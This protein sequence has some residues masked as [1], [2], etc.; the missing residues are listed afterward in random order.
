M[1]FSEKDNPTF[2]PDAPK[3]KNFHLFDFNFKYNIVQSEDAVKLYSRQAILAFSILFSVLAGG[4]LTAINAKKMGSK[5]GAWISVLYSILYIFVF[6]LIL[7][8]FKTNTGIT[9]FVNGIGGLGLSNIIW[10]KYI[11]K[12]TQYKPKAIWIPL[13]VCLFMVIIMVWAILASGEMANM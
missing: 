1:G 3:I 7:S 8:P 10:G 4:I 5:K 6:L 11:G 12:E 9:F 2:D 13:I